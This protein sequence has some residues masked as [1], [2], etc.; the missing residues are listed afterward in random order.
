[1]DNGKISI[2]YARALLLSAKEKKVADKVYAEICVIEEAFEKFPE[3]KMGIASPTITAEE[4]QDLLISTL[5]GKASKETEAFI[6]FVVAQKRVDYMP[7]IARMYKKLYR[8]DCNIVT[9]NITSA[10]T[11]SDEAVA[12]IKK[13]IANLSGAKTIELHSAEDKSL[14]GGFVLDIDNYRLDASIKGQLN[15]LEYYAGH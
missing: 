1:M 8:E 7:S 3:I 10:T 12:S 14:I 9:G 2:R 4:K 6:K 15:K 11:L 13:Y 5:N